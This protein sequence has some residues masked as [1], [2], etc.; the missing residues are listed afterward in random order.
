MLYHW[1][2]APTTPVF[3]SLRKDF[4]IWPRL[5]LNLLILL[6][7]PPGPLELQTGLCPLYSTSFACPDIILEDTSFDSLETNKLLGSIVM[8]HKASWPGH[9]SQIYATAPCPDVWY[10]Y[11]K[12]NKLKD[13][14]HFRGQ[15]R[16]E[17]TRS[18]QLSLKS[19]ASVLPGIFL[20]TIHV[21]K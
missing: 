21:K 20:R 6:P 1:R 17:G 4:A 8:R 18:Q 10:T 2:I 9:H 7:Q 13:G 19:T 3:I 5:A 15:W 12:R 14:R 11:C 16:P